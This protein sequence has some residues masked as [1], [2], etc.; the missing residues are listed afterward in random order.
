MEKEQI[1]EMPEPELVPFPHFPP[2]QPRPRSCFNPAPETRGSLSPVPLLPASTP[3]SLSHLGRVEGQGFGVPAYPCR[4]LLP[5]G[6]A[7]SPPLTPQECWPG[8]NLRLPPDKCSC[9]TQL[10]LICSF[11]TWEWSQSLGGATASCLTLGHSCWEYA[12]GDA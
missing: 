5:A 6:Q 10:A 1:F 2:Q 8:E 3:L 4:D 9:M 12:G 7:C 11:G